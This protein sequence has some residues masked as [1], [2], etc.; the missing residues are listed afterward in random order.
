[1]SGGYKRGTE[2]AGAGERK[3]G[4]IALTNVVQIDGELRDIQLNIRGG[5]FG[6]VYLRFNFASVREHLFFAREQYRFLAGQH[7][8]S[9]AN[10]IQH[11]QT[12][13]LPVKA[14]LSKSN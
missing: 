2:P 13:S 10:G 11:S 8:G 3:Q 9:E 1:M 14:F 7:T 12:W 4:K 5:R 6:R